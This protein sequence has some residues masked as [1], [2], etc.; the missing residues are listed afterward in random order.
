MLPTYYYY[1]LSL[2]G[3]SFRGGLGSLTGVAVPL[4]LRLPVGG[5]QPHGWGEVCCIMSIIEFLDPVA[6]MRVRY[7]NN[8]F[9]I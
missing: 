1:E 3:C 6:V 5:G 2:T 7:R 4:Y 8:L 9:M